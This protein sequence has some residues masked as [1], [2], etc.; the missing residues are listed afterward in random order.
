MISSSPVLFSI[1]THTIRRHVM[2][3]RSRYSNVLLISNGKHALSSLS[4]QDPIFK[5]KKSSSCWRQQHF[6][7]DH[8]LS[9]VDET[10]EGHT[11]IPS[12]S[13]FQMKLKRK[14]QIPQSFKEAMFAHHAAIVVTTSTPPYNIVHVNHEWEELCGYSK[15]EVVGKTLKI[16]QGEQTNVELIDCGLRRLMNQNNLSDPFVDMNLINYRKNGESFTNYLRLGRI[17]LSNDDNETTHDAT[18]FVGVLEE[19]KEDEN[20]WGIL[21]Y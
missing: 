3:S 20:T 7:D 19:I 15:N 17:C 12:T 9:I 11:T 13:P 18:F 8:V 1:M 6:S 16:I 14:S 2:S 10:K 21:D 5:D 4:Y